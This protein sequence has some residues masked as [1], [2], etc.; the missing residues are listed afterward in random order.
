MARAARIDWDQAVDLFE[1]PIDPDAGRLPAAD[2]MEDYVRELWEGVA[3]DLDLQAFIQ[4]WM[5]WKG[6]RQGYGYTVL[7]E[8]KPIQAARFVY[9]ARYMGLIDSRGHGPTRRLWLASKTRLY[10]RN[11]LIGRLVLPR[12]DPGAPRR[13][14]LERH[15]EVTGPVIAGLIRQ[16]IDHPAGPAMVNS[17]WI[18]LRYVPN[19]YRGKTVAEAA[20]VIASAHEDMETVYEQVK[21]AWMLRIRLIAMGD[22]PET[23]PPDEDMDILKMLAP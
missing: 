3:G 17:F 15:T 2:V 13:S 14:I 7:D 8:S 22:V 16:L 18:F 11:A 9:F 10:E 4:R 1:A 19:A 5:A 12:R 21:W 23:V 20:E 6:K